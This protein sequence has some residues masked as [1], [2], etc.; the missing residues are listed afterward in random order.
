VK[1]DARAWWRYAMRRM[2][3]PS[4]SWE[5]ALERARDN[6]AYVNIYTKL[7]TN[8]AAPLPSDSKLLKES[9]E[10]NREFDELRALR[11]VG[12]ESIKFHIHCSK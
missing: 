6:V 11:Q 1:E 9:M 10:W 5:A 8:S 2:V 3:K 4:I 12:F 7:L